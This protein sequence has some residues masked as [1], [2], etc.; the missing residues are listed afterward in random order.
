MNKNI[1]PLHCTKILTVLYIIISLAVM[2]IFFFTSTPKVDEYIG[3]NSVALWGT[4]LAVLV[5]VVLAIH[6]A[7]QAKK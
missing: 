1:A 3:V 6:A 4:L 2:G 7:L 5:V